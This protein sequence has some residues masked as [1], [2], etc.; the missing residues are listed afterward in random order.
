M[1][2]TLINFNNITNNLNRANFNKKAIQL[3]YY[4]AQH[5]LVYKKYLGLLGKNFQSITSINEI[6]CLPVELFKHHKIATIFNNESLTTESLIFKSSGTTQSNKSIHY[7][8]N[9]A[10]YQQVLL[11]GFEQFYGPAKQYCF[12]ALLPSYLEN[13]ESSLVFMVEQLMQQSKHILNNFY[14]YDYEGLANALTTLESTQ[15]PTILIGV[16]FALLDFA[17]QYQLPLKYTK[18]MET[19]GMKGRRKEVVR[20]EVHQFLKTAFKVKQIH[21]EYGMTEL[22]SQSYALIEDCFQPIFTKKIIIK[23]LYDPFKVLE[24]G[25]TGRIN[26]IDLANIHSCAFIQTADIGRLNEDGSFDVLGR[27]DNSDIRGCNLMMEL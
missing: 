23:D 4:Q 20:A 8:K 16:T 5:N 1:K 11:K 3:F 9:A 24:N 25:A 12:L 7:V 17:E 10:V 27:M 18:I 13:K 6:P 19:G 14:L 21:S 15:Q 26:V 22:L 2:P